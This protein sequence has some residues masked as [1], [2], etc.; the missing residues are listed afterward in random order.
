MSI[1]LT[2]ENIRQGQTQGAGAGRQS[3]RTDRGVGEEEGGSER[4]RESE[5]E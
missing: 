5:R 2:F 3:A 4:K 1:E